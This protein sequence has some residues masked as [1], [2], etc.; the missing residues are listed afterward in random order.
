MSYDV[1][2]I[3]AGHNGL[4]AAAL[5]A[6]AGRQ[7]L[8]LE[9]RALAGGAAATEEV[10]PG[11]RFNTGAHSAALFR[12]EI[13][14]ELDLS[15]HGLDFFEPDIAAL[16][17]RPD[18]PPLPFWKDVA[19]TCEA[20]REH[21]AADAEALPAFLEYLHTHASMLREMLMHPPPDLFDAHFVDVLTWLKSAL[22]LR[23]R[24][25]REMMEFLRFLPLTT[26]ELLDEWFESEA[27]Q[28][29]FGANSVMGSM[30]GPQSAGTALMLLYT[31]PDA[32][33]GGF[34]AG[35]FV[36][37]G[38]G[39]LAEALAGALRQCGGEVRYNAAVQRVIL[40]N[41]AATGVV[42]EGGEE[43]R[44]GV[45][46]SNLDPRRTLFQLVGAPE[47]EV[48][49]IRQIRNV[50]YRGST[51]KANFALRELPAFTGVAD[52]GMLA[53]H[54]IICPSLEHLE[55]AYDDAKYGR[56]SENPCLDIT[57]PTVLDPELAPAGKHILSVVM[58]YAPYNPARR[59]CE[60]YTAFLQE[61]IIDTLAAVAPD[62]R[63]LIEHVQLISP[64]DWES[65][66]GLTGGSIFHGQMGLDQLL[67]MRPVPGWARYAT[68]VPKLYLC[69]AGTHPG[70][71]VTGMP[72]LL[73]AKTVLKHTG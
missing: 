50:K 39:R 25:Q 58:R 27:V 16:S 62:F 70:G 19:R 38:M 2:V 44:S 46:L 49:S 21:S 51:A 48:E 54:I 22:K 29:L 73:A 45:I 24:G 30:A 12:E 59:D 6:K 9:K 64:L 52:P 41:D 56:F 1:I 69:S 43:I 34:M 55:R 32:A 63:D 65:E 42:L 17:L 61:K 47:L 11:F 37:G 18:A 3:G 4:V 14:R 35:R 71:G 15:A 23:G 72:G 28:G 57:I 5:L 40:K 8:V 68:P 7:V 31:C 10:F 67:F 13:I 60:K 36:K 33:H 66:Y 26:K 53:G 20:F